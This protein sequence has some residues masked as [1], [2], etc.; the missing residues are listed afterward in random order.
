MLEYS[1][2]VSEVES[3]DFS[4]KISMC[5]NSKKWARMMDAKAHTPVEG[6][7]QARDSEWTCRIYEGLAGIA[8]AR[9]ADAETVLV[10]VEFQCLWRETVRSGRYAWIFRYSMM[11]SIHGVL[12][13]GRQKCRYIYI[14]RYIDI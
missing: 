2:W 6:H 10:T 12:F 5:Q 13:I 1:H 8:H 3:E 9:W 14:Y 4:T 7:R 11:F